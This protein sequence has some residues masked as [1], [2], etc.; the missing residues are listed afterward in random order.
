[1]VHLS[2]LSEVRIARISPRFSFVARSASG[3]RPPLG[4]RDC[5]C[6]Q[7]WQW[8]HAPNEYGPSKTLY[9]RFIR[10]RRLGVFDRIFAALAREGL[11]A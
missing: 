3:R 8:K 4:Q 1:M 5:L 11:E 10:W 7:A 2:L 6:H 9:N